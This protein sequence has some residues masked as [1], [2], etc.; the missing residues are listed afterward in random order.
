MRKIQS[1]IVCCY[2]YPITKYGYPP[3][4]K[5]TSVYLEEMAELGF[6]SVE[7]EGIR[8]EH[9]LQMYDLRFDVKQKLDALDLE[10]PHFCV[11]LP[12]L[13]AIDE[14]ERERNLNLFEKGCEIAALLG[15]QG[16]LD[17][18]PLPPYVFADDIP[19]VRHYDEEVLRSA[20]LP[21][22]LNW[23]SYFQALVETY[24]VAC[25]LAELSNFS[26]HLHPCL[27]ALAATTDAFLHFHNA[28]GR[29][30]LR[31]NFDTANQFHLKDNL[32]LALLRLADYVDYI[33]L[34]D[35]TG[36]KAGPSGPW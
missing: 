31:F 17:N 3:P 29:D 12:G 4:T 7:L 11:V 27:G 21:A 23:R 10:V 14:R 6:T 22:D 34:S 32:I 36:D 1:N 33:H 26:F 30:N 5:D 18:G 8:E 15:A 24:R 35:N 25:D 20:A 9:L 28:V 19:V 13:S 16:V 2:L